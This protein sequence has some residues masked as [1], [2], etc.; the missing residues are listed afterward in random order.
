MKPAGL[1]R[2]SAATAPASTI[3]LPAGDRVPAIHALYAR[4]GLPLAAIRVLRASPPSSRASGRS[5]APL[6]IMVAQPALAAMRAA[7]SL[8]RMPPVPGPCV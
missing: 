7:S 5:P 8:V 3:S 4:A 2:F 6:P 1:P